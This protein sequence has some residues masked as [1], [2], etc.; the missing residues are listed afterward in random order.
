VV[1]AE[2]SGRNIHRQPK[3]FHMRDLKRYGP[4]LGIA[5]FF[6]TWMVP[7]P[8]EAQTPVGAAFTYQGRLTDGG[9]PAN[10]A[11]DFEFRLFD[12]PTGGSQ[13]GPTVTV[14]DLAVTAGL[15]SVTLD[16]SFSSF[17]GAARFLEIGIRPGA[18]TGAY[19][20]LASRQPLTPSPYAVDSVKLG[21]V[22]AA[23]YQLR[24]ASNCAVGSSIRAIAADGTVTCEVAGLSTGG[25]TMAGAINMGGQKI[26]NLGTPTGG[27]DA[28]SKTYVDGSISGLSSSVAGLQTTVG[29]LQTTVGGIQSGAAFLSADQTFTGTN[30]FSGG[31]NLLAGL[32]RFTTTPA[33]CTPADAGLVRYEPGTTTLSFCNGSAW[34]T[35]T[36]SP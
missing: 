29:G 33:A 3:G 12:A 26:T 31:A 4:G 10:A 2:F 27:A 9:A 25:G 1:T 17:T 34:R 16:F 30:T 5:A 13:V 14:S 28:A 7:A 32:V 19:T 35:I 6:L 20:T 11:Y 24:V 23:S 22:A 8:G 18:S 15:F 21:G 36:T